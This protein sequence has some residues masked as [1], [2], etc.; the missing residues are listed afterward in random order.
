MHKGDINRVKPKQFIQLTAKESKGLD[1]FV[2]KNALKLKKDAKYIAQ[3]GSFSSSTSLLI[4]ST[5]ELIKSIIIRLHSEGYAIYKLNESSKFF[6]DHKIR[7]QLAR[8]IEF[9]SGLLESALKYE[10]QEPSKIMK[11]QISWLDKFINGAIDIANAAKPFLASTE[12]VKYLEGFNDMKNNGFYVDFRNVVQLPI[13][14]I[15]QKDY[16][17]VEDLNDRLFKF[18]KLLRIIHS[19]KVTNHPGAKDVNEIKKLLSDFISNPL[20]QV[21]FKELSKVKL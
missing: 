16:N 4:L 14:M 3:R 7:H 11:T 15:V 21:S 2:Y 13:E 5:E 9:G 10:E 12:R 17:R 18:A 8:I 1:L 20:K 6:R 19:E